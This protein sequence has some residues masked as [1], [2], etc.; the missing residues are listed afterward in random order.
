MAP[1]RA[2]INNND[3]VV[4]NTFKAN[5]NIELGN[6]N[7]DNLTILARVDSSIIPDPK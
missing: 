1:E 6:A 4:S 7:S 2:F 5:G 3:F